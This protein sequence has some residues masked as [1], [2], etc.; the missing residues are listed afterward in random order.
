MAAVRYMREAAVEREWQAAVLSYGHQ[1][2]AAR[3][4]D[5]A[6]DR[7]LLFATMGDPPPWVLLCGWTSR[8]ALGRRLR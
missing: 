7:A 5:P 8:L 3:S 2:R 1:S 6:G 4:D